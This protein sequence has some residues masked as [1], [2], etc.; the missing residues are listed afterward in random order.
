[1]KRLF[2][3]FVFLSALLAGCE[4]Q[5]PF[6]D[7]GNPGTIKVI[8]FYDDNQ[9]GVLDAGEAGAVAKVGLSQDVSCPPTS[10]DK[11]TIVD[12]DAE[13]IGWFGDLKP[14][15]YCISMA[16]NQSMTTKITRQVF[17]SSDQETVVVFGI[18][19]P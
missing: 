4:N 8:A 17:V 2:L 18:V 11:M 16:E 9:N 12:T 6:A 3:L 15:Q 13:G 7:N 19:K 5:P 14:G 1:M 10:R